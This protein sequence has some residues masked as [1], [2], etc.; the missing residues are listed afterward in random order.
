MKSPCYIL[1]HCLLSLPFAATAQRVGVGTSTPAVSAA[2]DV[3][4]TTGGLLLPRMTAA[5][6]AAIPSPVT[7]LFVFQTNGTPGLYYYINN[8][9]TN[10]VTNLVPDANGRTA[11]VSTLAGSGTYSFADGTGTAAQFAY[12]IGIAVDGSGNVYVA[13]YSNQRIRKIVVATGVVSTL[14]GSGTQGYANGTGT[15]A[16]FSDPTSVAVD[17]TGTNVYVADYQNHRIRKIVAATGVV[18]TLAGN[19]TAGYVDGPGTTAQ[20]NQ[21]Y[22]VAAD[23]SGN[24]YVAGFVDH[25]IRKIVVATGVVSTLAGNGTQGSAN[26]TGTV[27]RFT[28]PCGVAVDGSGNLF[29]ADGNN[30][31]IRQ[32][33]VATGVVTTLAGNTSGYAEGTGTAALFGYPCGVTADGSGNVYVADRDNHRIRKIVVATGVVSTLAGNG[34]LGYA[35]GTFTAAQFN[36]PTGVAVD[37]G[38]AVYVIDRDNNRVRIVK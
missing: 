5:Q 9:W 35:D 29:V 18:T 30:F 8:A 31:R 24:V 2:L 20:F 25:S 28:Y 15:A 12:P 32:I 13:D 19:G 36:N 14:A 34:T 16:Q 6:R 7:G 11:G 27:A 4:S 1:L 33:V 3:T 26:G 21:P 10:L 23:G 17:A 22:G 37:A 38:G